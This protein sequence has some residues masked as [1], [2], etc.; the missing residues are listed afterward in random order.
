MIETE[1]AT[2]TVQVLVSEQGVTCAGVTGVDLSLATSGDIYTD[3]EATFSANVLPDNATKP[4]TYTID[5]GMG[6]SAPATS[7]DDP[8]ELK[9]TF[10][11]TGTYD[12][13]IAVWNCDMIA[14]QAKKDSVTLTVHERTTHKIYLPLVTR[15]H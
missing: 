5:Y 3:T 4:Y 11:V 1:A 12:V 2:E 8:L 7:S 9:H 10:T 13:E 6:A 14:S 15:N